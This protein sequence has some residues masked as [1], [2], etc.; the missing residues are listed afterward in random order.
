MPL[1]ILL[2]LSYLGT[3]LATIRILFRNREYP[4]CFRLTLAYYTGIFAHVVI[5][6]VAI[7]FTITSPIVTWLLLSVGL[8]GLLFEVANILTT[9]PF[10]SGRL[11][12]ES[13]HKLLHSILA[14]I[15]LTPAIY[16]VTL[17]LVAVPDISFDP[18]AFWNL[19]AKYFFY[20]EHLWTDTFLDVDRIN[21]HR[22]YPL[23]MPIFTFE[24]YSIIGKADDFST[25]AGTW[26]Y[27][28][29]GLLLFFFL[30]SEWAGRKVALLAT[31]FV[32]Y[33]PAYSYD[34]YASITT[35]Y[36][37]FPLSLMILVSTSFLLRYLRSRR[38]VDFFGAALAAS[39][40]TLQK[41]EGTV[42][43][44][45]F[46]AFTILIIPKIRNRVWKNDYA[47]LLLPI[48]ILSGWY[49][50]KSRLPYDL[51]I[52]TPTIEQLFNLWK[53]APK[54]LVTWLASIFKIEP[55]G[56]IPFFTIPAF[57]IGLIRNIHSK[58]KLVPALMVLCYLGS[59]FI[60][61]MLLD[62]QLGSFD[63]YMRVSYDRHMIHIILVSI[64]LAVAMNT[65]EFAGDVDSNVQGNNIPR[66]DSTA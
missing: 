30:I 42:W 3:G 34:A 25:K 65:P 28:G 51:D 7:V 31:S 38:T 41:T 22:D 46:I 63:L 18:T 53:V 50:I 21:E 44:V 9:R 32:L 10:K 48:C 2:H 20:S 1:I 56:L 29:T 26:I 58:I 60:A 36:V 27:Y 45:L 13:K 62:I 43:A 14:I 55:W 61:F 12:D 66:R 19:K 8:L 47:W 40:A 17:R 23:Y 52:D 33:S 24:H 16:L 49:L 54:M 6:H 4:W 59:N 64:F 37:D 15:L 35:T 57:I 11:S 5:L 39:S